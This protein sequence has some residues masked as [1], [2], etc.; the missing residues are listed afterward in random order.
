MAR[1][2]TEMFPR[3]GDPD[4]FPPSVSRYSATIPALAVAVGRW[5][6]VAL[7]PALQRATAKRRVQFLAGR[8]CARMAI[9]GVAPEAL[10]DALPQDPDGCPVWPVRLVGSISHTD[11]FATAAVALRSE[12]RGLGVD[13]EPVMSGEA[14]AEIERLI[15]S[16][17]ETR[18]VRRAGDLAAAE[19]LTL[20]FSAK[21]SLYKALYPATRQSFEYLDC[22]IVRLDP[23]ERR[24]VI[25][26][27]A[28]FNVAMGRTE[29]EGG[30]ELTGGEVRTG[31]VVPA[32]ARA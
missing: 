31:V 12:A 26:I 27:G 14:T 23:D 5:A 2:V 8:H 6:G 16:N 10:A 30:Y 22:E 17:E 24:F 3:A 1:T 32:V 19:A 28:P 9:E 18:R 13:V 21:E 7:P 20:V 25:R 11:R 15:A 29:F 4:V